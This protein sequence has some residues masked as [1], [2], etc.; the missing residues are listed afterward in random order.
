M[1]ETRRLF[2]TIL[3]RRETRRLC[4]CDNIPDVLYLLAGVA[5][6]QPTSDSHCKT[7]MST[8]GKLLEGARS[9]VG[10]DIYLAFTPV[11]FDSLRTSQT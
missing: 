2:E 5:P 7:D 3:T 4:C 6:P 9:E 1:K 8:E 11:Q 10:L